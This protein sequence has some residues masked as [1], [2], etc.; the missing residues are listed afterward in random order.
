M[1][2]CSRVLFAALGVAAALNGQTQAPQPTQVIHDLEARCRAAQSY[3]FDANLVLYTQKGEDK[4][5]M[6]SNA[7][8]SF[9]S[10]PGG[11]FLMKIKPL[12]QDEYWLQSDGQK[13]WA[14]V[15][16]LKKYT[17]Q[18][19]VMADA[20]DEEEG[21]SSDTERDPAEMMA[22]RVMPIL[23]S[24]YK[25][26]QGCDRLP[27]PEEIRYDKKKD[28]WPVYR[29][30]SRPNSSEGTSLTALAMDPA[31]GRIGRMIWSN[32]IKEDGQPFKIRLELEFTHFQP[33][34]PLEETNF[35]FDPPKKAKLAEVLPV[36]GQTGSAFL[37][38]Q[39][40]E[41][42]LKT[43]DGEVV[44]LASLRGR[45]VL[46]D[47]WATW[48]PPCRRELP[49]IAKLH[50]DYKDKGLVVFGVNDEGKGTARKYLEKAELA[51][52]TLDDSS[53]KAHRAFRVSAIPVVFLIDK[54][55]KVV[56]FF[57]GARDEAT[58]R[59]ALQSVGLR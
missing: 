5:S 31:T 35:T 25:T 24:I 22:R 12:E 39:A 45:P 14:Y 53:R 6:R 15:P 43:L 1:T 38:K 47:F 59:S 11:K 51:L 49:S 44:T 4:P 20:G 16:N 27:Q 30:L 40:P 23:S 3:S 33:G 2:L 50:A 7:R 57:R 9:S 34:E 54:E 29:A 56:R 46:I 32:L 19:S 48:C 10:A 13:S 58:L 55:G 36:P 17:E 21:D 28:K 52:P 37:N 41:F 8:V 42:E 18:E 26:A